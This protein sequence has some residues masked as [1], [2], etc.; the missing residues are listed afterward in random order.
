MGVR[1]WSAVGTLGACSLG[2]WLLTAMA[3]D[4]TPARWLT[5]FEQAFTEAKTSGKP[6]FVVFRC[7]H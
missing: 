7:E 5:D 4:A 1:T 3:A 2:I 6:V